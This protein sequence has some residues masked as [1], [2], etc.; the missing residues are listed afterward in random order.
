MRKQDIYNFGK[1]AET[2]VIPIIKEHYGFDEFVPTDHIYSDLDGMILHKRKIIP[3][4]IKAMSPRCTYKDISLSNHQYNKYKHIAD[5][6]G[7]YYCFLICCCHNP[8]FNLDYDLYVFDFAEV[9]S[10]KES[11]F[12]NS[13]GRSVHYIKLSD[14]KHEPTVLTEEFQRKLETKHKT[15]MKP[16]ITDYSSWYKLKFN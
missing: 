5:I 2:S 1:W 9:S 3:A 13:D 15:L 10:Y 11:S 14:M 16:H 12:S 8:R 7:H 6:N 4:Q